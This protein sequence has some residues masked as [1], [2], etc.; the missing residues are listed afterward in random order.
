MVFLFSLHSLAESFKSA[1]ESV[2][3]KEIEIVTAVIPPY[4]FEENGTQKGLI[5]ELIEAMAK[6]TGH[7]GIVRFLPWKRALQETLESENVP[8]MII[9]LNRSEEREFKFTWI[10]ELYVDDTVFVSKRGL[11]AKIVKLED[12]LN[13]KTGV[14]L[15]S[16]LEAQLRRIGFKNIE[17]SV[18]EDTNA[19]KLNAGRID[20]WHV[21]RMVAPF[22][23]L[24][25]GLSPTE[26][27]YGVSLE[28]NDLYLAG[29]KRFPAAVAEKWRAA[30]KTIKADGTYAGIVKKYAL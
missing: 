15:G 20:I 1:A 11:T 16:P 22:V 6:H 25:L 30:F 18:D 13:F 9:P 28:P 7:S 3:E 4:C 24:R 29:S 10:Q 23:F 26:L 5:I 27:E 2:P 14:L 8:R 21:A 19:R 17:A 12:A